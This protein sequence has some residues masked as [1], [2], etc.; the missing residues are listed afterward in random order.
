MSI[1]MTAS[2]PGSGRVH[3]LRARSV[4]HAASALRALAAR[5]G[6]SPLALNFAVAPLRNTERKG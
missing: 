3:T 5:L 2:L 4:K 1:T 6:V